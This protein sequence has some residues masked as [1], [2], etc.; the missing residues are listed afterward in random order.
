MSKNWK[1]FYEKEGGFKRFIPEYDS[2]EKH[3]VNLVMFLM[4][5]EKVDMVLD[6]GC[7][8]GYLCYQF[9]KKIKNVCGI[10]FAENRVKYA[11]SKF[12]EI[13]FVQGDIYNLP[14]QNNSYDIITCVEVLEHIE[15]PL[16]AILELKRVSRDYILFTVP[17]NEPLEKVVCPHCLKTF[18]LHGHIQ[19]F[20]KARIINLCE[21]AGLKIIKILKYSKRYEHPLFRWIPS[22]LLK[23]KLIEFLFEKGIIHGGYIGVLCKK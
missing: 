15:D 10:D 13:E 14:I 6:V 17:Y 23:R 2:N 22:S 12:P 5:K 9:N 18:Y 7:G 8:D 16:K 4:P 11:K 21:H 1:K 20:N 3:R 19:F